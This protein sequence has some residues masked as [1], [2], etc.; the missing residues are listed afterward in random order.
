M[1]LISVKKKP[2]GADTTPSLTRLRLQRHPV[3][4][5]DVDEEELPENDHPNGV[6]MIL[7][8]DVRQHEQKLLD[9]WQMVVALQ[10]C[11]GESFE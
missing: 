5:H 11:C 4:E 2:L 8:Q 10:W 9:V 7:E 6:V 1:V 3:V